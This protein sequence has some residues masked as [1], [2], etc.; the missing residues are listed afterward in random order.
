M[1]AATEEAML[2]LA[3]E[4]SFGLLLGGVNL[5][6][7]QPIGDYGRRLLARIWTEVAATT[8]QPFA[9]VPEGFVYNS[10]LPCALLQLA[11]RPGRHDPFGMLHRLQQRFFAEGVDI[12]RIEE[13][14]RLGSEFGL[15]LDDPLVALH[16]AAADPALQAGFASAR[17]YGTHALPALLLEQD[18]ERQLLQGGYADGATIIATVRAALAR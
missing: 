4:V 13:L 17:S 5:H 10:L 12:N 6:A 18:G 3:D 8:H 14:V 15:A 9:S 11:R 1:A 2:E 16:E 7:T